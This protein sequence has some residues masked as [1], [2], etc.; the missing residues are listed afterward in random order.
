MR[1]LLV[2]L[3]KEF[4]QFFR[5]AFLPKMVLMF[6]L[7]VMLIFPWTTTMDV[8]HVNISIVDHDHSQASERVINK[9]KASDYFTLSNTAETYSR[10][11]ENLEKGKVDVIVEIPT[12]F[13]KGLE[14]G[15]PKKVSI[16]ANT[17][18]A[19]KGS[20]GSQYMSQ[21]VTQTIAE[22]YKEKGIT[23]SSAGVSVQYRY[24]P[25]LTYRYFMIP[26]LMIMLIIMIC[27]FLPALNIVSEKEIGT[28]EQIN[29]TPVNK[30]TF[31]LAKLIPYWVMG[32]FVLGVAMIIA[33]LVYGLTPAG[34]VGAIFLGAALAALSMSGLGVIVANNSNTVQQAMFVMFFFVMIFVLMSGLIT[35][36]ESMPSW[37]Q[38]LTYAFPPRYFVDIMRSVYLKGTLLSEL[39]IDYTALAGLAIL[40]DLLAALTYKKQE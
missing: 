40:L 6:P 11:L 37:A 13:E 26:A 2:L 7:A 12:D 5:N 36:I 21:T 9:V 34:S 32:F 10:A 18:N 25:T 8:H 27:G 33:W 17:V 35:P 29:V 31:T 23:F 3:D 22:L 15:K 20:L 1:T 16:F 14:N 30:F 39:W 38:T 19:V 24:N 4:R 28:I